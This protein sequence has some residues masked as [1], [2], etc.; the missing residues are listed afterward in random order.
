MCWGDVDYLII[1]APSGM[2]LICTEQCNFKCTIYIKGAPTLAE[3][4]FDENDKCNVSF[5]LNYLNLSFLS[6]VS[7]CADKDE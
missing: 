3:C 5:K 4:M 6:W 1:C 7:V 2:R